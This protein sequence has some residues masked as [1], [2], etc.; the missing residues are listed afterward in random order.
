[1]QYSNMYFEKG[2]YLYFEVGDPFLMYGFKR[3]NTYDNVTEFIEIPCGI[4]PGMV[5]EW[6]NKRVARKGGSMKIG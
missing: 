3:M 6:N 5:E 1:M 4:V 2:Y